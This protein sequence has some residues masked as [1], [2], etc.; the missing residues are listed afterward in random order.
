MEIKK[1]VMN[2]N[3]LEK[4]YKIFL[5]GSIEMGKTKNWQNYVIE[6]LKSY[7]NHKN[8]VIFNPCSGNWNSSIKPV[9]NNEKFR[10][11]MEWELSALDMADIILMYLQ[12]GTKS[13][14]S[15]LEFGL[16]YK[17]IIM[18]CP[19]GFWRKGNVDIV[20]NYYNITQVNT[21]DEMVSKIFKLKE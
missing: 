9:L 4:Y 6:K 5:A 3:G 11:Q 17:K 2:L 14:I 12:P 10:K 20:C 18:C 15:L 16:Y 19:D 8:I 1:P 21:I 13:P 7:N